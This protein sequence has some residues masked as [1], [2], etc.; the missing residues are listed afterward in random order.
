MFKVGDRVIMHSWNGGNPTWCE[1]VVT[2]R[3]W[4]NGSYVQFDD[5]TDEII[6]HSN[7]VKVRVDDGTKYRSQYAKLRGDA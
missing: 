5:G 6:H 3:T 1:G 2:H 4:E 7:L